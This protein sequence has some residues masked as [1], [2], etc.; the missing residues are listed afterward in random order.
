VRLPPSLSWFEHKVPRVLDLRLRTPRRRAFA[1]VEPP[2]T[3]ALRRF[4]RT[5]ALRARP[6][7][8]VTAALRPPHPRAVSQQP[9]GGTG[10]TRPGRARAQWYM[11]DILWRDRTTRHCLRDWHTNATVLT[12]GCGTTARAGTLRCFAKTSSVPTR[13]IYAPRASGLSAGAHRV[14]SCRTPLRYLPRPPPH[15]PHPQPQHLPLLPRIF[16]FIPLNVPRAL[17]PYGCINTGAFAITPATFIRA[18][19]RHH[20]LPFYRYAAG[21]DPYRSYAL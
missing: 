17:T 15:H 14:S 21:A 3:N 2:Y 20:L 9:S 5:R 1:V 18:S 12:A 13:G 6:S 8:P 4:T 16:P 7:V 11:N 19:R 10:R